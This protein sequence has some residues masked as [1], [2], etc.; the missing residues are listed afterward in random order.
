MEHKK[1]DSVIYLK[2]LLFAAL[3]RW[4]TILVIAIAFALLLGGFKAFPLLSDNNAEQ[5]PQASLDNQQESDLLSAKVSLL[6]ASLE[7]Q[8]AYLQDSIFM[9]LNPYAFYEVALRLYV[10]SN[11]QINPDKTYQSI[12]KTPAILA[13]YTSALSS[14]EATRQLADAIK[15]D[16]KYIPE[17]RKISSSVEDGMLSVAIQCA[18]EE[19]AATLLSVLISEI[20]A[21][22]EGINNAVDTHT[23]SILEEVIS[24]K[25]DR[26][27]ATK[28]TEVFTLYSQLQKDLANAR[29]ELGALKSKLNTSSPAG[30]IKNSVIFAIVG[31]ILGVFLSVCV[32]WVKH[33]ASNK[34]YGARNLTDRTGIKVISCMLCGSKSAIDRWLL[35]MEG[36]CLNTMEEQIPLLAAN[37]HARCNAA[38]RI[39]VTGTASEENITLLTKAL[40]S[41]L[42]DLQI[43]GAYNLLANAEAIAALTDC[44]TVLLAE[45]C[46]VSR[47]SD[48]NTELELVT[49]CHKALIGYV[50]LDG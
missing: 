29:L 3:Y 10:D 45:Q 16:P 17:L 25:A 44:D 30:I 31:V 33:I 40:Q 18:N 38:N 23:I 39:F 4:R 43:T 19:D 42:P 20:N 13:A 5:L 1:E 2:D 22:H 34:V 41:A 35:S 32:I 24:Q 50:L 49:D 7:D 11:Y 46:G 27:I 9:Q 36:R 28:Q 21:T 47:Y 15:T 37:I 48:I 12:D 14:D 26:S 8:K 6:E